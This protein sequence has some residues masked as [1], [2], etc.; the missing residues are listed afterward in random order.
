M[1]SGPWLSHE[2]PEIIRHNTST[3]RKLQD[4]QSQSKALKI[5]WPELG[6]C[7]VYSIKT[8]EAKSLLCVASGEKLTSGN[9][10]SVS[11]IIEY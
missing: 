5:R 3:P 8:Q 10:Y 6:L 7:K 9:H 11:T 4:H 1:H 2:N